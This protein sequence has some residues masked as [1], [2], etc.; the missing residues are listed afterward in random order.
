L[1]IHFTVGTSYERAAPLAEKNTTAGLSDLSVRDAARR[2]FSRQVAQLFR[3][4][5]NECPINLSSEHPVY[6]NTPLAFFV[7]LS[8]RSHHTQFSDI[9]STVSN[10]MIY[11]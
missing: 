11:I 4:L 2:H 7:S 9:A 10:N 8:N 5:Q 1:D 6:G 3:R